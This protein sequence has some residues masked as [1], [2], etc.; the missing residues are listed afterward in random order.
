[1]PWF[2]VD[3]KLHS[4]KKAARA[5]VA[6]MGL[7]TVAGSW[8][9]DQ[10]SDGF[11]PDY[12]AERL[13]PGEATDLADKLVEAGLWVV[14]RHDGDDGWRFKDWADYQPT[15]DDVVSRREY[16]R[17]KK[18]R[19]RRD[20]KGQFAVSPKV[21]PRDNPGDS[22]RESTRTRPDPTR[23]DLKSKPSSTDVD[24][25][26]DQFDEFWQAYP[27][28][29]GKKVGKGNAR[30]EWRKLTPDQRERALTGAQNLA[31]S[32]SYP[33]DPER[34]LR[35]AKGGKGDF[36]FDDWQTPAETS[37]NVKTTDA[38]VTD[39][40]RVQSYVASYGQHDQSRPPLDDDLRQIVA[41]VPGG[42]AAIRT[43]REAKW[44]FRDAYL[45]GPE[46]ASR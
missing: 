24:P 12:I 38:W 4:H 35:K 26:D 1:M 41:R 3:D 42:L 28:R 14:D 43:N 33:K 10:L 39:W 29:N 25:N 32:D 44:L 23:P 20:P 37:S 30:I 36:P 6:A 13:A 9:A 22:P 46:E 21:S 45:A 34:F 31:A 18:R 19:Q 11:V 2:K 15:R 16:E 5:G 27:K 8:C 40:N 7:W 17:D